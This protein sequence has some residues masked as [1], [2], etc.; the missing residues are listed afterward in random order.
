[1]VWSFIDDFYSFN[2]TYTPR[3]K[4]QDAD[5]MASM[6]AKLLPDFRLKKNTFYVELIFRPFVHDDISN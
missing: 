2:I 3:G 5:L 1:V 6:A 4:N